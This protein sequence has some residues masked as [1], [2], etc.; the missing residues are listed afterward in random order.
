MIGFSPNLRSLQPEM[1]TTPNWKC[2]EFK[3]LTINE[4]YSM[5][6]L[7]AAVF[8]LE[9]NC[10][11]QDL[12][13]NDQTSIHVTGTLGE[14]LLC[15]ARILPPGVKYKTPSIGRVTTHQKI[16]KKG[17][18]KLLMSKAIDYCQE[19]WP[20]E[21]ITIS[22]QQRLQKFYSEFGFVVETE[23]YLEDGIPHIQM[24]REPSSD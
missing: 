24:L 18:G 21:A 14:E 8:V 10:P 5:L 23:P 12:D 6:Q 7:R 16:R 20:K 1:M 4:L 22:A 3:E 9:Q 2:K 11:Y 19:H 17:Y 13:G 15:Y